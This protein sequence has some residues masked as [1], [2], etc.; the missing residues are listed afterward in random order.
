MPRDGR[1]MSFVELGHAVRKT[2]NFAP[3]FSL[4]VPRYI[5]NI[6]GRSYS[7]DKLDLADIDVHNGIEHDASLTRRVPFIP[8]KVLVYLTLD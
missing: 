7:R 3:S 5:S 6:L 2:Y 1:N 8:H 4:F